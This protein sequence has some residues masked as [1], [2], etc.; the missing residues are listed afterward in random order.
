[1]MDKEDVYISRE[2][3]TKL[4][5]ESIT[6]LDLGS[7][8]NCIGANTLAQLEAKMAPHG[9]SVQYEDRAIA[10]NLT[11]VGS[12]AAKCLQTAT[13]PI[14]VQFKDKPATLE[15]LKSN[16]ATGGRADLLSI[17]GKIRA[18]EKDS[19]VLLREGKEQLMF[20]GPGGYKIEWSPG[21]KMMDLKSAPSDNWCSIVTNTTKSQ[22]TELHKWFS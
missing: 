15:H 18:T 9:H 10:L 19:V 22:R 8:V 5:G 14:A 13:I 17:F 3:K 6:M 7:M 2:S 12:G 1:M 16:V 21:T 11:G 4:P 20:P